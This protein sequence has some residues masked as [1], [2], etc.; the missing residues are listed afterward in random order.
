MKLRNLFYLL[1][2]LPLFFA[3]CTEN[4]VDEPVAKE[5]K[6]ELTS[7]A[8][9]TFKAE[10]GKGTIAYK[11]EN[12]VEGV[13]LSATC[14]ADWV[15][16]LT[17]GENVTFNVAPNEGESRRTKVVVAYE[18]KSF[19]VTI[20]QEAYV[21]AVDYLYDETMAYASRIDLSE[22]G[23]P[24]FYY[25]IAFY[26]ADGNIVLGAVLVGEE[27][28][29]ILS[30]GTY[31]LANGG[32]ML[33]GFELYVG[34]DEEYYFEGG[35]GEVIVGGDID[36]YTFDIK[37]A[38]DEGNNFH[39]T[40]EGVVEDMNILGDLPT[41][42]VNLTVDIMVGEYYGTEFSDSHS[43]FV[44]LSDLGYD[45]EG[46]ALPGGTY[47]Q[48]DLYGPEGVVD[49]DGYISI[50]AG[51]YSVDLS[52]SMTDWT[53]SS[54]YSG[55]YKI[56]ADG[57]SY[58]ARA[59]FESGEAVVTE[60][61]ITLSVFVGGVQHTV[62]YN[63]PT[64]LYAG[65]YGG[66]E[67]PTPGEDTEFT[68]YVATGTY[69]GD[70]YTP[71]VADNYY[72]YLSDIGFDADGYAQAGGT[73]YRFDIY[74][75]ITSD[76]TITPGTY[77]IDINDTLGLGTVSAYYSA[78]FKVN[79]DA[80]DYEVVDYPVGGF[81]TFNAD[82][83]IYAEVEFESGATH[84]V[85][86]SGDIVIMD[87]TA[88]SGGEDGGEDGDSLSMLEGDYTC[89]FD[90]HT[91]VYEGYGDY[92][93][94]GLQNWVL[95]IAPNDGE[96]GDCVQFDILAGADSTDFAGTYAINDSFGSY[97]A[98]PGEVSGG[99][100]VGSW[101][102][103]GD[104]SVM[105]P[106]IDGTLWVTNNGNGTYTVAFSLYD[107][108]YNFIEGTWT[109][110]ALDYATMST[111]SATLKQSKKFEAKKVTFEKSRLEVKAKTQSVKVLAPKGLKLR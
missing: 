87:G 71:G 10:G 21:P 33:D 80:S 46:Y 75:P 19:E 18:D 17:V 107:D 26:S 91:L 56:S 5:V 104:Y 83:T 47:Y 60:N 85:S 43:Y 93:G 67:T 30:A 55:F 22:Y 92:Y 48:L 49:A 27:G 34:D 86:F 73:Y 20:N 50:P 32:L 39:F 28:E 77:Y 90:H 102:Y 37:L 99:Y 106:F 57:T 15:T 70:E 25:L 89:A 44:I 53:M 35:D 78:Y 3:G 14:D 109:G 59:G 108:A 98:Y 74:A 38:D 12:P 54:Y 8:L 23:Y 64:K 68:A 88:G 110:E 24:T 2:A 31:S 84:K 111:R 36:G 4:G 51:T 94:I 82:N 65:E 11:L 40:Y 97:T 16:D 52:D 63:G 79:G 13:K 103:S 29:S 45:D 69:Y 9:L 58:D 1:L 95:S 100:L 76:M 6:L 72:F 66:G 101:Y 62:V 7:E 105:A 96:N 61:G 81:I 41:E 42:P